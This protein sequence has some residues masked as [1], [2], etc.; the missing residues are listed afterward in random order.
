MNKKIIPIEIFF[1]SVI[2]IFFIFIITLVCIEIKKEIKVANKNTEATI[3]VNNIIENINSRTYENVNEYIQEFSGVG[4]SKKI[5]E[6]DQSIIITG[7]EFN[8]TFFGTEIPN[9]YILEFIAQNSNESFDIEKN[10]TITLKYNI[11]KNE[12]KV[13]FSTILEKENIEE[14]NSPVINDFYFEKLGFSSYDYDIIPIKYSYE[15]K[16]F[17]TTQINDKEWYNYSSKKWA[18]VLIFSQDA[19]NF[20]DL[21]IDE[22]GIVKSNINYDN[23]TINITNYIYVWIP[24]FTIKDNMTYFRYGT[25]KKA[26]KMDFINYNNKNLYLNK[27][28]EEIMDISDECSFDGLY[29]VWR[30]L[31][32]ENDVYYKIF[33]NTKY[34]PI[35]IY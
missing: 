16:C 12:E 32:D 10:I 24:N 35:N 8:E 18:K 19:D 30:K 5:N 33:N 31:G 11:E 2:V 28:S 26:I 15:N 9:E 3:I 6:K 27:V 25:S 29:G 1:S 23:I 4:V 22:N 14:C 34:G 17:I 21:F 13:E 7:N 20:K